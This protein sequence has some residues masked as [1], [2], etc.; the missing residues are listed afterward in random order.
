MQTLVQ[1]IDRLR[2]LEDDDPEVTLSSLK[3]RLIDLLTDGIGE[4][5]KVD[6]YAEERSILKIEIEKSWSFQEKSALTM[7]M[8]ELF[9]SEETED[10]AIDVIL[11]DLSPA[12]SGKGEFEVDSALILRLGVGVE[13][14]KN[15]SDVEITSFI[16]GGTGL[17]A[18]FE[19]SGSIDFPIALGP[20]T[21]SVEADFEVGSEGDPIVVSAFLDSETN[22]YLE[23][24]TDIKEGFQIVNGVSGLTEEVNGMFGGSMSATLDFDLP[25]LGFQAFVNFSI[26]EFNAF[27][28][29]PSSPT[30][31]ILK[32]EVSDPDFS[33][34]TFIDLLLMDPLVLV[35]TLEDLLL[36]TEDATLGANGIVSSFPVPFLRNGLASA[37][38]VNT[39]NNV[40]GRARRQ[41]VSGVRNGLNDLAASNEEQRP[42]T[43]GEALALL[44]EEALLAIDFIREENSVLFECFQTTG[45]NAIPSSVDCE[46]GDITS[47]MWTVPLGQN[48]VINLPLDF[49]LDPAFPLEIALGSDPNETPTLEV[50]WSFKLA[51]GFDEREGFFLQTFPDEDGELF[52]E[53][54]LEVQNV[55]VKASLFFLEANF[56]DIDLLSGASFSLDINKATGLRLDG[57]EE[58]GP[59]YGRLT[60]TDFKRIVRLSDLFEAEA[61]AGATI[62]ATGISVGLDL[63]DKVDPWIPKLAFEIAAQVRREQSFVSPTRSR[64]RALRASGSQ[65]NRRLRYKV[66]TLHENSLHRA[67]PLLRS[68]RAVEGNHLLQD[69][70]SFPKCPVNVTVEDIC[71]RVLNVEFNFEEI[72]NILGP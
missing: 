14:V 17:A 12:S 68:L 26:P 65:L 64:A 49:S 41:V 37:L 51:F 71:A 22:F 52:I 24:V 54:L 50:G 29:D 63:D 2:I 25:L 40:L 72:A 27:F 43:V 58:E 48:S 46:S 10:K 53:A 32:F 7:D 15:G 6:V 31:I 70:F 61:V 57:P 66:G 8:R 69:D 36:K 9:Q 1:A 60:A 39:A 28:V 67:A 35:D 38:G 3:G 20:L 55:F 18:T 44:L 21:G 42:D 30:S 62:E 33:P 23:Q 4:I 34:P 45:G 47:I 16:M 5:P 13:V 19:A 59:Q 56:P 11:R